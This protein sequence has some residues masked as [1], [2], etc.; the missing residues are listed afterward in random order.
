MCF[1]TYVSASSLEIFSVRLTILEFI[2]VF[3]MYLL[4]EM[5]MRY[6]TIPCACNIFSIKED[7][8]GY[9]QAVVG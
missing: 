2:L 1:K 7:M 4:C 9:T 6:L 5:L 8:G 3:K